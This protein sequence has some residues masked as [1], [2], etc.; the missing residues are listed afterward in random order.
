[1]NRNTL[2]RLNPWRS[3]RAKQ[4]EEYLELERHEWRE[5]IERHRRSHDEKERLID[6]ALHHEQRESSN[7]LE[8]REMRMSD[9][10]LEDERS[11]I[12]AQIDIRKRLALE[13]P[14]LLSDEELSKLEESMLRSVQACRLAR[15]GDY[16]RR[17]RA[18]G[19]PMLRP[20]DRDVAAYGD[21]EAL[22]RRALRTL[23]LDRSLGRLEKPE[24]R[25]RTILPALSQWEPSIKLLAAVVGLVAGLIALYLKF[26]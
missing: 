20:K 3:R 7:S 25:K 19:V 2:N 22:V 18:A 15:R 1:M 9:M 14:E 16:E 4:L 24:P 11:L 26:V 8:N 13:Y 21:L 6:L 5:V 17:A 23:A 12:A 10:A